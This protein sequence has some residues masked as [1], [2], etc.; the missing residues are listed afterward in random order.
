MEAIEAFVKV[1]NSN[2]DGYGDGYGN[3]DGS[4]YGYGDGSGYG[5][6]DGYGDGSGYGYGSSY[7]YGDGSGYSNGDGDGYGDGYGYG[8]K[9]INNDR[10]YLIDNV[11]TIIKSVRN[12]IAK[13]FI[14]NKDLTLSS[15]Y[16]IKE[17]NVFSHGK[18]LKDAVT[19]LQ[20]KLFK[21][22]TV[23]ERIAKFKEI[24]VDYNKKYSAKLLFDW[25]H[26]LTLSCLFGRQSFVKN[27]NINL[28][29]DTFTIYE[30]I[31]LTKNSYNGEIIKQL[32]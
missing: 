32:S 30:F 28:D 1:N 11:Q 25:H 23:E 6:G 13:G 21:S 19:S 4:G 31:E 9:S 10:V 14:L 15:C 2:G 3:S 24:F 7:G 17:N 20:E 29:T 5:Y 8:V 27:N 22:F 26:N 12:N 18:T 16:I